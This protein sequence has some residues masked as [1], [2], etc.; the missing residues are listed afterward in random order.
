[1]P[2]GI[3]SRG[4]RLFSPIHVSCPARI[5]LAGGT[6][7]IAPLYFMVPGAMTVNLAINWRT[8]V[9]LKPAAQTEIRVNGDLLLEP[10]KEPLFQAALDYYQPREALSI[11]VHSDIPRA[12]GLGGSSVLLTALCKAL[13][14]LNTLNLDDQA[15]LEQ[16][17]LLEHRLL[18][19]PAGI[20]DAFA[21]IK[22]GLNA[23]DFCHGKFEHSDLPLCDFLRG[24]LFLL[25]SDQQHHSGIN[26]WRI[27][28]QACEGDERMLSLLK[29]LA[30]NARHLYQTLVHQD[31]NRFF[32]C[33]RL[34]AETRAALEPDLV[35][36]PMAEFCRAIGPNR[37][38][39]I[40]GAGGG[41]CMLLFG[42]QLD[43]Q[44]LE[45]EAQ[46]RGLQ[47][48]TCEAENHGVMVH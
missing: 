46:L 9:T 22:G 26:N 20:Q 42:D 17:T 12:A 30:S 7:D 28:K 48:F 44:Q 19:K 33:L 21:A 38:G 23:I 39:K 14:L 43:Q 36:Q 25:Y 4:L 8:H 47:V 5:D 32:S 31:R 1:M 27:I 11:E 18:M 41:G 37:V 6:L 24:Q 15:L 45:E 2:P 10:E 34:E 16:V 13:S 3:Y 29:Q 40:C 35:P